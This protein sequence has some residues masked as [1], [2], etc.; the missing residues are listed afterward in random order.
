M[1]LDIAKTL[2]RTLASMGVVF[3]RGT[4]TTII[5]AYTREAQDARQRYAADAAI[6]GLFYDRHA[7]TSSVEAFARG[8][9]IAGE[10][11]LQDPLGTPRIPSWNRVSSAIPEIFELLEDTVEKD[12][13]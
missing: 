7:E 11:F 10:T 4:F 9:N 2:F 3:D 6:N 13:A 12:H 1:S 8:L 5:S